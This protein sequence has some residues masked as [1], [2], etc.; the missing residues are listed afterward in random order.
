MNNPITVL[1]AER[2]PLMRSAIRAML[3]PQPDMRLVGETTN[4][5]GTRTLCQRLQP[6]ILLLSANAVKSPLTEA[7]AKLQKVCPHTKILVLVT[8]CCNIC[9][10]ALTAAGAIGCILKDETPEAIVLTIRNAMQGVTSLSQPV[11]DELIRQMAVSSG[12]KTAHVNL[13]ER[14]QTIITL[15]ANGLA[16]KNIAHQLDIST[17][18]VEFH[19][20]NILDKLGVSTRVEAAL[21]AREHGLI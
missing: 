5:E 1:I 9:M 13:T 6:D 3:E 18:T 2:Q 16:N 12:V 17:R 21:W 20:S 19:V 4:C 11:I 10:N 8:D 7:L 15:L 14:E